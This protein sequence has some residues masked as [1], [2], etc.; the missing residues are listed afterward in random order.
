MSL[1]TI[2]FICTRFHFEN[3]LIRKN[4]SSIFLVVD[5]NDGVTGSL[6]LFSIGDFYNLVT[7]NK[8]FHHNLIAKYRYLLNM[9]IK[10]CYS[11]FIYDLYKY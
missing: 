5:Y 3:I 4:K 10:K 11:V 9:F 2:F 6:L 1:R 8:S 7:T